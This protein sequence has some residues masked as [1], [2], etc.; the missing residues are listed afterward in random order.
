MKP[1]RL[2]AIV[3]GGKPARVAWRSLRGHLD[4]DLERRLRDRGKWP[5]AQVLLDEAIDRE[6]SEEVDAYLVVARDLM[7]RLAKQTDHSMARAECRAVEAALTVRLGSPESA[8]KP[9]RKALAILREDI[10]TDTRARGTVAR[11]FD[12]FDDRQYR[13]RY[14]G[15]ELMDLGGR[16]SARAARPARSPAA[17]ARPAGRKPRARK[18]R[19]TMPS[20]DEVLFGATN[21]R[22]G[23]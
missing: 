17:K 21:P 13:R 2:V 12:D 8:L 15:N 11:Y 18:G 3:N 6:P 16:F 23:R 7:R 19:A 20:W 1:S 14:L 9:I 4:A 5:A 22:G 10:A